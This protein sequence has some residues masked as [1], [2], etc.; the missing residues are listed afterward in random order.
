MAYEWDEGRG[1]RVRLIK[2]STVLALTVSVV[3]VPLA[4]LLT[5]MPL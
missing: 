1:R 5:A 2:V 4:I 3:S